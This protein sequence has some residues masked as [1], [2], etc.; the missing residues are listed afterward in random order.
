MHTARLV[1]RFTLICLV[2]FLSVCIPAVVHAAPFEFTVTV[3]TAYDKMIAAANRSTADKLNK[4]YANLKALQKQD[5]DWDQKISQLRYKNEEADNTIRKRIKEIDAA[6]IKQLEADAKRTK[7]RYQPLFNL[8]DTQRQQLSVA[9]KLKNKELTKI[10]NSTVDTTKIAVQLAKQ[11]IRN[12]DTALKNAKAAANQK[13]KQIRATLAGGDSAKTRIKSAKSTISS[14]KKS[15]TTESKV[16]NQVVRK[17]DS[18]ASLSSFI[19]MNGYQRQINA[20]KANI[21][22]YEQQIANIITKANAQL[23]AK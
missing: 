14:T 22:N 2:M 8:Y 17:G 6:K 9:K 11:D 20:Q 13:M 7:E 10:L 4:E 1:Q 3:K 23:T 15:F 18:T 12:K 5:I 19:R 21:Y 16:L